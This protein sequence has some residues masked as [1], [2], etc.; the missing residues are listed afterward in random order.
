MSYTKLCNIAI[1]FCLLAVPAAG[2]LISLRLDDTAV[3]LTMTNV[4]DDTYVS[5]ITGVVVDGVTF[6]AT[7]TA[8]G[9]AGLEIAASGLGVGNTRVNDGEWAQFTTSITNVFGGTVS[10]DGFQSVDLGFFNSAD[11]SIGV[12]SSS[13]GVPALFDDFASDPGSFVSG[14]VSQLAP[15]GIF[16]VGQTSMPSTSVSF[17]SITASFSATA[18]VPEPGTFAFLGLLAGG[19]LVRRARRRR[20]A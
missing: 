8:L 18:A 9:S 5:T 1:V 17:D 3:V 20:R 10:F 14:G 16:L 6:D 19:V 15:N 12:S 2:D 4:A 13:T 11:D 7:I